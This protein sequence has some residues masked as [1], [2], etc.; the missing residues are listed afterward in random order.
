LV[1]IIINHI[2]FF[3]QE[4]KKEKRK[5]ERENLAVRLG[6]KNPRQE[7]RETGGVQF[8]GFDL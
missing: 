7:R 2:L 1:E 6:L 8:W 4:K 3:N 5:K